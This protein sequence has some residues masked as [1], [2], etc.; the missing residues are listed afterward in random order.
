[1]NFNRFKFD[2]EFNEKLNIVNEFARKYFQLKIEY[3]KALGELNL[4]L[5]E[6]EDEQNNKQS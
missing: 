5:N 1:M 4:F 3:D 2:K 6:Q